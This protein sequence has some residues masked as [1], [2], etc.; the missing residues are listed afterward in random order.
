MH[1]SSADRQPADVRHSYFVLMF[2]EI[3]KA[4]VVYECHEAFPNREPKTFFL[5]AQR[6]SEC[7]GTKEVR[8]PLGKPRSYEIVRLKGVCEY[9]MKW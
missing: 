9:F 1:R 2:L 8:G 3:E 7:R 5:R 4:F 6:S